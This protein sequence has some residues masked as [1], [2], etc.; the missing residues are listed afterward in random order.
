MSGNEFNIRND[1]LKYC[2]SHTPMTSEEYKE[3]RKEMLSMIAEEEYE[4]NRVTDVKGE[5]LW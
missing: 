3:Y 4:D 2:H 5:L 1:G